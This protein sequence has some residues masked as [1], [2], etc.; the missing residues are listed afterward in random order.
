VSAHYMP[1][2][3]DFVSLT[4]DPQAGREPGAGTERACLQYQVRT[5]D[6]LPA[7]DSGE[8]ISV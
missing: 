1:E 5:C 6:R 8:R 4:F 3:R 7:H 2:A